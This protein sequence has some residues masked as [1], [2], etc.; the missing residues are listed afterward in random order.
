MVLPEF[1]HALGCIHEHQSS[2]SP[3]QWK[4]PE[5]YNHYAKL[6]FNKAWVDDQIIK[7]YNR[8]MSNGTTYDPRSIMAY[9]IPSSITTSGIPQRPTKYCCAAI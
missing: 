9:N 2:N 8:S 7:K 5:V 6:G 4:I 3:I 1:G